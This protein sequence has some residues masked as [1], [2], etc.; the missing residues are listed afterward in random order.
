[1]EVDMNR[2]FALS[3]LLVIASTAPTMASD[4]P[5]CARIKGNRAVGDC[6][7][8]S[9]G[10]CMATVSGQSGYCA[11]NPRMAYGSYGQDRRRSWGPGGWNNGW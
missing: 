9:Y 8:V 4:Y 1:M 5:W 6:S 3:A 10:Q 2:L 11:A 7:F